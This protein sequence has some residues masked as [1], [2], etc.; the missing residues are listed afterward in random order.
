MSGFE[1]VLFAMLVKLSEKGVAIA[2]EIE[3]LKKNHEVLR[4]ETDVL[5]ASTQE[6]REEAEQMKTLVAVTKAEVE[7]RMA[8]IEATVAVHYALQQQLAETRI[9][10]LEAENAML[11]ALLDATRE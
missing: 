3:E 5:K 10:E 9:R 8:T 2:A 7:A 1:L 11:H 6:L 4:A